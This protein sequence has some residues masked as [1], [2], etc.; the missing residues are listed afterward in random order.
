M[1]VHSSETV[2]VRVG[3][4]PGEVVVTLT[5]DELDM[6]VDAIDSFIVLGGLD[7]I[8]IAD[9]RGFRKKVISKA[10]KARKLRS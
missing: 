4:N 1:S 10:K 6:I 2:S 7:S 9:Y 3:L 8:E 5:E